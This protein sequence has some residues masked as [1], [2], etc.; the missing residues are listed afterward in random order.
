MSS[1]FKPTIR[2]YVQ[3][4]GQLGGEVQLHGD[5]PPSS[6]RLLL[7]RPVGF[8]T[9]PQHCPCPIKTSLQPQVPQFR[10]RTPPGKNSPKDTAAHRLKTTSNSTVI[11]KFVALAL[12]LLAVG[13]HG[14]ALQADAPSH[15]EHARGLMRLYLDS[16][17]TS[18]ENI[19]GKIDDEAAKNAI[20]TRTNFIHEQILKLQEQVAPFTDS[21]VSTLDDATRDL[22]ASIQTDIDTLKAELEPM[23][24]ELHTVVNNHIE[25]Y[26][27]L[28]QPHLDEYTKKHEADVA[29]WKEKLKPVMT[30][31][32][33]KIDKNVEETKSKLMPIIEK[34]RGKITERVMA[35]KEM[36]EPYVQDYK[37]Q[38]K[39]YY[40]QASTLKETNFDE[41]RE[42]LMPHLTAVKDNLS[43]LA[44][45]VKTMLGQ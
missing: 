36:V 41:V 19:A 8:L 32:Q 34:I 37:D 44:E 7:S 29:A 26:K 18:L 21:A 33:E 22:R 39:T 42:K 35:V 28:L 17:K 16:I 14:A 13:C 2:K 45:E 31:L 27:A 15:L 5:S 38:M 30:E 10:Q 43:K 23:R 20:L 24:A 1:R 40:D 12:A 3:E 6:S 9:G 25:E 4:T 11:M